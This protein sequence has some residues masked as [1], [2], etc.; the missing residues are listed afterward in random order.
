MQA[1]GGNHDLVS[2]SQA[3]ESPPNYTIM[4][5]DKEYFSVQPKTMDEVN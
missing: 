5:N 4:L 2:I 3:K 1:Q